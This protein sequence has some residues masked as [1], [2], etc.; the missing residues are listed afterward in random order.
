MTGARMSGAGIDSE[1]VSAG[2]EQADREAVC[3]R[4]QRQDSGARKRGRIKSSK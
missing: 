1:A 3:G 2:G 4:L